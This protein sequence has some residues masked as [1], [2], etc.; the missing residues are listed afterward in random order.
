MNEVLG[1]ELLGDRHVVTRLE[2]LDEPP[3]DRLVVV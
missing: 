1:Q 3:H 2:L